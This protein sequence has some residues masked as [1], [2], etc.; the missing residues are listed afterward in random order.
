M[1]VRR[2]YAGLRSAYT[3]NVRERDKETDI[4]YRAA[5]PSK[6]RKVCFI[7][8]LAHFLKVF[9]GARGRL[10]QKKPPQKTLNYNLPPQTPSENRIFA[11]ATK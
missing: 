1:T 3:H 5:R 9:S 2:R 8:S 10:F 7:F 6:A 11:V 4:T